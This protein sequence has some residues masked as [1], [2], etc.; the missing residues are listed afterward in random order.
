MERTWS[1]TWGIFQSIPSLWGN[2]VITID[3]AQEQSI[4]TTEDITP[5]I[6]TIKHSFPNFDIVKTA[7][8]HSQNIELPYQLC[9]KHG[10]RFVCSQC[11]K[12]FSNVK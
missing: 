8:T 11:H 4:K 10:N 1:G 2:N 6:A 9:Y 12:F 3:P 5:Y 7:T